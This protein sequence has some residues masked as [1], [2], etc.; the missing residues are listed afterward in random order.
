MGP[1]GCAK[2]L[3]TESSTRS[4]LLVS[5]APGF[6]G[7]AR[8]ASSTCVHSREENI[9]F[10]LSPWLKSCSPGRLDAA[11]RWVQGCKLSLYLELREVHQERLKFEGAA[12][13]V[14]WR[15]VRS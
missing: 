15:A 14:F 10:A 5:E 9:A 2:A 4:H 12:P 8:A 3:D 6:W 11:V 1:P 13:P 7:I